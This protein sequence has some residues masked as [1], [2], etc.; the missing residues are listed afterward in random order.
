MFFFYCT[1]IF[2]RVL[3]GCFFLLG[4][5][6]VKK[7]KTVTGVKIMEDGNDDLGIFF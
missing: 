3:F 6:I 7:I 4:D 1:I 2:E 5:A